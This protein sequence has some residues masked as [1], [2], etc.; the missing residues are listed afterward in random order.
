MK[1]VIIVYVALLSFSNFLTAQDSDWG[2]GSWTSG[3]WNGKKIKGEGSV[4]TEARNVS[5]FKGFE[6][7]IA[8]DVYIKQSA[9]FKV[10]IEGQKNILD[11]LKTDLKGDLLKIHFEKGYKI[12]SNRKMK[13]YIE[14]P[15]FEKLTMSGSGNVV[16]QNKLSGSK[17]NIG[18]SGSG[19]FELDNIKFGN[20]EFLIS[21]SGNINVTG[22]T[23]KVNFQVSGSGDIKASDLKAQSVEC[24]VSGSGNINCNVSKSLNA[25]VS[26]SG[27]IRYK[28]KPE[29]IKTKVSGSGDIEA[30]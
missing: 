6:S 5:G 21:G 3:D 1:K 16:A 30:E 18:I 25:L 27:D 9:S 2:S 12:T 24:H 17:I 8:A 15:S 29:T 20:V 23:D 28:G 14:A 22:E 26:G 7:N 4:V 11:L 10:T 13:I 19:N